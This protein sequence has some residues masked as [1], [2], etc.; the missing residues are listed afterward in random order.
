MLRDDK[1]S[2]TKM[3]CPHPGRQIPIS[4]FPIVINDEGQVNII[5]TLEMLYRD[6]IE[7]NESGIEGYPR[8][9]NEVYAYEEK[10]LIIRHPA[11]HSGR[12]FYFKQAIDY[13]LN[14]V[15]ENR[16]DK[17]KSLQLKTPLIQELCR[18]EKYLRLYRKEGKVEMMSLPFDSLPYLNPSP[19]LRIYT[20]TSILI[21]DINCWP[22]LSDWLEAF[23]PGKSD[24]Y[25]KEYKQ[26]QTAKNQILLWKGKSVQQ[27]PAK[28][29]SAPQP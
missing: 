8:L 21:K 14:N 2:R 12:Y 1:F 17:N 25:E 9:E 16:L 6:L 10:G 27:K 15:L 7:A 4:P 20:V 28:P 19:F 26:F 5:Q 3:I 11:P 13:L 22:V 23:V 18:N 29:E 24:E